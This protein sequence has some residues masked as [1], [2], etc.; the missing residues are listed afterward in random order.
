MW[1]RTSW[2]QNFWY[3][4]DWFLFSLV[5]FVYLYT[6]CFSIL[7]LIRN[8]QCFKFKFIFTSK[9]TINYSANVNSVWQFAFLDMIWTLVENNCQLKTQV[10]IL[11]LLIVNFFD[12]HVIS[13][14]WVSLLVFTWKFHET[15]V[16]KFKNIICISL[17]KKELLT[18]SALFISPLQ[19]FIL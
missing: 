3:T 18:Y 1:H 7:C 15:F 12:Y 8:S 13:L 4:D 5:Y 17:K 16:N 2:T 11:T 10:L 9:G 19:L 6:L 14:S